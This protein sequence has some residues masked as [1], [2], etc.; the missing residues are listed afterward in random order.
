MSPMT[1]IIQEVPSWRVLG[2]SLN[3]FSDSIAKKLRRE[4]F[5]ICGAAT[6]NDLSFQ[7]FFFFFWGGIVYSCPKTLIAVKKIKQQP[8]LMRA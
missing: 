8:A 4:L 6:L 5:D 1:G 7:L 3:F 2:C